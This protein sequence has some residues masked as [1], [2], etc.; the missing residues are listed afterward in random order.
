MGGLLSTQINLFA[1]AEEHKVH[2]SFLG[3]AIYTALVMAV[4]F[5]LL[6]YAKKGITGKVFKNPLTQATEQLYLFLENMCVGIIGPG[7]RKYIPFIGTLWLVIFVGNAIAL[8]FGFSPTASLGF[9]L[10][11]AIV[12][13]GYVQ[14]EGIKQN[15]VIG[16]LSHFAGPKMGPAMI[17]INILIFAIEIVSELMKNASLSLRLF[18]NIFGGGEAVHKMN[19]L[20]ESIYIPF[21]EFLMPIKFLTVVVQAMIFTLLTCVYLSLVTHH[22]EDHGEHAGDHSHAAVA[23]A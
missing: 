14:Y 11:M 16:H 8:I 12:S 2:V 18:G 22:D 19:A 13:I 17:L 6:T 7:G 10:G 23:H 1:A 5:G 4:L 21:G 20:G 9:N 3:V 15:G